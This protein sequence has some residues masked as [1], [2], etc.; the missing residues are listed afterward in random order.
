M[1]IFSFENDSDLFILSVWY[2]QYNISGLQKISEHLWRYEM[3]ELE[4]SSTTKGNNNNNNQSTNKNDQELQE[5]VDESND[6][7]NNN[8]KKK[9]PKK[10]PEQEEDAGHLSDSSIKS[11]TEEDRDKVRRDRGKS[12]PIA[13]RK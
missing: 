6:D 10:D 5:P 9:K 13:V 11:M 2:L 4:K 12:D 1:I 3:K 8:N 7:N